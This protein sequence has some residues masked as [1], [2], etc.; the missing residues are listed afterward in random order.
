VYVDNMQIFRQ[1]QCSSWVT[2]IKSDP[3]HASS[4]HDY[5]NTMFRVKYLHH[6]LGTVLCK[7]KMVT[8]KLFLKLIHLKWN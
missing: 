8:W 2:G 3:P 4:A 6:Y 1:I 7:L 5:Q